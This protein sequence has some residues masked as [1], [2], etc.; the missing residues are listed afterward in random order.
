MAVSNDFVFAQLRKCSFEL[1]I[2]AEGLID[3]A[4]ERI[5]NIVAD[6]GQRAKTDEFSR[7]FLR[8]FAADGGEIWMILG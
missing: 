6:A 5:E 8:A 3:R 2:A 1:D 4:H 7:A